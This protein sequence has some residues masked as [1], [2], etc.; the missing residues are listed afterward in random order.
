MSDL[1]ARLAV[2]GFDRSF[3]RD[4][5]LPEWWDDGLAA[6][7]AN[8]AFA[9]DLLARSLGMAVSDLSEP[10][11]ALHLPSHSHVKFKRFKNQKDEKVAPA[12]LIAQR[13]ARIVVGS[14]TT[15]P[16]FSLNFDSVSVRQEILRNHRYV[17]LQSLLEFCWSRG[18]VVL[19]LAKAPRQSKLF[20]G[21][22]MF[23]DERP[24]LVL[25]S[26]RDS[27]AWMAFDLAHE[28][29]HIIRGHV[30]PGSPPLAD[31]D[32]RFASMDQQEKEADAAALELLTGFTKPKIRDLKHNAAKLA[33]MVAREGPSI[34]VDPGVMAL[35]YG[36]SNDRWP[37]AQNAL[38]HLSLSSGAHEMI[39]EALRK[40]FNPEDLS[41]SSER[42][43]SV[44]S[45]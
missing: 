11:V 17:D 10:S 16:P 3:V 41:E 40:R 21:L 34:G 33:V 8:R 35:I 29:A 31:S 43:L 15:L 14:L 7:P 1:Y 6:V 9:E 22:A 32:L 42:F 44:L 38:K 13:A 12:L 23:C 37:V 25:G 28:M 2:T 4:A 18:V 5:I 36:K 24:V 27:P 45:I 26:R 30:T 19:H 20:D 39:A